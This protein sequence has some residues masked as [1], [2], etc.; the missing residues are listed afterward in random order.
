MRVIGI[1]LEGIRNFLKAAQL[2]NSHL[3]RD[4]VESSGALER[5]SELQNHDNDAISGKAVEIEEKYFSAQA[6]YEDDGD[7]AM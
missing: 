2:S 1:S 3:A 6:R 4:A 7:V 5:I